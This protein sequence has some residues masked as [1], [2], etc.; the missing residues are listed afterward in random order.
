MIPAAFDYVA[1]ASLGEL[2]ELLRRHGDA[3]KLLSGGHS[4]I[5][6]LKQRL[7]RPALVIDLRRVPGLVG[8]NETNDDTVGLEIGAATTHATIAR[9]ELVRKRCPLLAETALA[10]GDVQV[11]N[12]GTIGGSLAH[13]DPAADWPAALI[14]LDAKIVLR[15]VDGERVVAAE[16]F[17]LGL[18]ETAARSGELVTAIRV[19][20]AGRGGAYL[21]MAQSASGFA[22]AGVAA[23]LATSGG[24]VSAVR[25]GVTG[26]TTF[27]FRATQLEAAVNG[28]DGARAIEAAATTIARDLA[29]RD[30]ANDLHASADY[31]RHLAA[32]MAKRALLEA[33]ERAG[34]AAHP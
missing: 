13:A 1:P 33:F 9:H 15:G 28:A 34:A 14:A 22:L 18:F 6:M 11:R 20:A 5:P 24:R 8:I 31:R 7:A 21:K 16:S 10:I 19:P 12:V 32:V 29:G 3:A 4:L 30:V 17:F 26:V 23:Q 27:A 25:I 2:F